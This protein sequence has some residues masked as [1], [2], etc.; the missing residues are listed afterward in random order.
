M[1]AVPDHLHPLIR[2]LGEEDLD[3]VHEIERSAY[4]H[5]WT[6]GIFS[7][8]LRVGYE[9]WG[10]QTGSDLIAYCVLTHAAGESHLLNLCVAPDRQRQGLGRLMLEHAIRM[11][12][13]QD[14]ESMFLEVRPSNPAG[15]GLYAARGF[16]VVGRRSD[17]YRAGEAREDAIVMQLDLRASSG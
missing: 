14:C 7:D 10:M 16:R 8:C 9:C 3:R 5:P 11:A 1:N 2:R 12:R 17:Y 6:R 13:L 15:Y 4:P